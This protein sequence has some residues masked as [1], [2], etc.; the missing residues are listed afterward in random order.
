MVAA[1]SIVTWIFVA[2]T[3][4]LILTAFLILYPL[5]AYSRNIAYTQGF[6]FLAAALLLYTMSNVAE[7]I[8]LNTLLAHL[9][10]ALAAVMVAAGVWYFARDFIDTGESFEEFTGMGVSM[11][12][13]ADVDIEA[14]TEGFEDE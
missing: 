11:E 1:E 10:R 13:D 4:L 14:E 5:V 6:V 2:Q 8:L 7:Y 12:M 3:V 9:S